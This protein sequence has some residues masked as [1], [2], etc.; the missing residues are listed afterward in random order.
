MKFPHKN[1]LLLLLILQLKFEIHPLNYENMEVTLLQKVL[2]I[3]HQ[4]LKNA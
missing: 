4:V 2:L 1:V 3:H